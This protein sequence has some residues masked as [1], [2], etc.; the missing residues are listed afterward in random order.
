[1][2]DYIVWGYL[3]AFPVLTI[4]IGWSVL[5][6][7]LGQVDDKLSLR[8]VQRWRYV[9]SYTLFTVLWLAVL[10]I[11]MLVFG[12]IGPVLSRDP[13]L[14]LALFSVTAWVA[15]AAY[16]STLLFC[17]DKLLELPQGPARKAASNTLLWNLVLTLP[18]VMI[19]VPSFI[20][21]QSLFIAGL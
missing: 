16:W 9:A 19:A 8:R 12:R 20:G 15:C 17:T 11:C 3:A 7:G 1:M 14:A 5:S 13:Y 2:M 6:T 4:A 18:Y 21:Q 10:G